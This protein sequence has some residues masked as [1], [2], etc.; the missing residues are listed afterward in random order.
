MTV[1][2]SEGGY[3]DIFRHYVATWYHRMTRQHRSKGVAWRYVSFTDRETV[4]GS[5][6]WMVI[7]FNPGKVSRG[8]GQQLPARAVGAAMIR[9][10][11]SPRAVPRA[12]H[13]PRS[14][15]TA[16]VVEASDITL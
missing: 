3:L 15:V 4:S 2:R 9:A 11:D 8:D 13:E 5:D 1:L 12:F 10:S 6:T 7:R 16:H 14:A